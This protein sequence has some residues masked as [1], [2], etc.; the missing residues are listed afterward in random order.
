MW[1][2]NMGAQCRMRCFWSWTGN[3]RRPPCRNAQPVDEG[4]AKRTG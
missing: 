1:A 4:W 2:T 3:S